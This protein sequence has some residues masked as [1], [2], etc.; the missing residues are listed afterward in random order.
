MCLRRQPRY[1]FLLLLFTLLFS[2]VQAQNVIYVDSSRAPGGNGNSWATAFNSLQSALDAAT[3]GK[4]IWVKKGT[5]FPSVPYPAIDSRTNCFKLKDG[6]ALYGGFVGN[7]TRIGQRKL[8]NNSILSGDLGVRGNTGDNSYHVVM[9]VSNVNATLDG[10]VIKDGNANWSAGI[11]IDGNQISFSEGAGLFMNRA[12]LVMNNCVF[13]S[14]ASDYQGGAVAV[15]SATATINNCIFYG[16][17]SYNGGAINAAGGTATITNCSFAFNTAWSNQGNGVNAIGASAITITNS[18]FWGRAVASSA[19]I[20]GTAAATYCI[21]EGGYTGTGN[22]NSNPLYVNANDP[23]G[24]DNTWYTA[25]DGLRL[26]TGS[27]AINTGLNAAVT[28]KVFADIT[29]VVRVQQGRVDIGA[30]EEGNIL[31]SLPPDETVALQPGRDVV[32]TAAVVR[33]FPNPATT[34]TALAFDVRKPQVVMVTLYDNLGC[35]VQQTTCSL[36]KGKTQV[37]VHVA[38]IRSGIYYIQIKGT[39]IN[40]L[41]RLTLQ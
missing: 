40:R 15:N 34:T 16:N 5:Y 20:A 39:D 2:F 37:P 25:D 24:P 38:G 4:Q 18:L 41:L 10:F 8:S 3:S 17:T 30:Y 1:S 9:A 35:L 21:V 36:P 14:H 11:T 31:L 19:M 12:T 26:Q 6:V 27:P 22:L 23:D 28:N 29:G 33:L 32:T 7:E 13:A